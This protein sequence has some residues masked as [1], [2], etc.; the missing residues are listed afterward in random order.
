MIGGRSHRLLAALLGSALLGCSAPVPGLGVE[1]RTD[2]VPGR[3]FVSVH[4]RV[5]FA[6]LPSQTFTTPVTGTSA[7]LDGLRVAE[8]N[9]LGSGDATVVVSLVAADGTIALGRNV[10][11]TPGAGWSLVV[12]SL[13]RSCGGVT[14]PGSGDDPAWTECHGGRCVHPRCTD[15]DPTYC[16]TPDCADDADCALPGTCAATRCAGGACLTAPD[17]ARCSAGATCGPTL[18]CAASPVDAGRISD[19]GPADAGPAD[20]GASGCAPGADESQPCGNCGASHRTCQADR[21]WSSWG[22]CTGEGCHPGDVNTSAC[23]EGCNTHSQTCQSDCSWSAYG[24]CTGGDQCPCTTCRR[25]LDSLTYDQC[26]LAASGCLE[27]EGSSYTCLSFPGT[28]CSGGFCVG[29]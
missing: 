2:L 11:V 8:T 13:Q 12:V 3:E 5:S 25:C 6:G 19:A 21:T 10:A 1:L 24:A 26:H 14:C 16:G 22:A 7:T 20:A 15:G 28:T 17:D 18:T 9:R 23:G 4:V 29:P 27:W